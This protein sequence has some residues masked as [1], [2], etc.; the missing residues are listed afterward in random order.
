MTDGVSN[1]VGTTV[2]DSFSLTHGFC[3]LLGLHSYTFVHEV[4]LIRTLSRRMPKGLLRLT[5]CVCVCVCVCVHLCVSFSTL[6][7]FF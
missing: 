6:I 1:V 5:V 3:C 7:G 2:R 4:L